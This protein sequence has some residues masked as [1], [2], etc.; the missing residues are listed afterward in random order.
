MV[1]FL[2]FH[3]YVT[4]LTNFQQPVQRSQGSSIYHFWCYPGILRLIINICHAL[5]F[6]VFYWVHYGSLGF[7]NNLF[8]CQGFG[9][10][11]S[12]T[13]FAFRLHTKP[14]VCFQKRPFG[15]PSLAWS[16][17][18]KDMASFQPHSTG[19]STLFHKVVNGKFFCSS[20]HCILS[21]QNV[22]NQKVFKSS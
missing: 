18:A 20:L 22:R 14:D 6:L 1:L 15:R 9:L 3:Q 16:P 13:P 19:T 12:S 10:S 2:N 21:E 8:R 17:K 11:K 5:E 4:G 7:I